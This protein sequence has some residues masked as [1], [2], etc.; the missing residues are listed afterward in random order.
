M[1]TG[2][3]T[4]NGETYYLWP[5]SDGWMGRM[6]TGLQE[7]GGRWYYFETEEGKDQGRM[8]TGYRMI[9]GKAYYFE[10]EA[11]GNQGRMYRNERTPDG[12][13]AGPDGSLSMIEEGRTAGTG[14]ITPADTVTAVAAAN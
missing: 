7:I 9:G 12:H 6:V 8:V 14:G 11:G 3:L 13:W 1:Q 4:A 10:T 5:V 2:W